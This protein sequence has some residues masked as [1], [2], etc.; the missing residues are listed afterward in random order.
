MNPSNR[1]R[2]KLV[3]AALAAFAV[4]SIS[5][6]AA[7]TLRDPKPLKIALTVLI[8][9]GFG[10]LLL[11]RFRSNPSRVSSGGSLTTPGDDP[12]GPSTSS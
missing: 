3:D 6:F 10:L 11:G 1:G 5:A 2:K 7:M 12:P 9:I 4:L 8:G